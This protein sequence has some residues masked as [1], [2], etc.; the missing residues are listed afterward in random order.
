MGVYTAFKFDNDGN[1]NFLTEKVNFSYGKSSEQLGRSVTH[2]YPTFELF[3]LSRFS[4]I[5][6]GWG[7]EIV[8]HDLDHT[9]L[10]ADSS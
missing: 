7:L 5:N 4:G 2:G 9:D 3:V 8:P 1:A 6:M 10:I